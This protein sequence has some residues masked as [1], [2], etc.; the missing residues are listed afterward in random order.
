MNYLPCSCSGISTSL[1]CKTVVRACFIYE[2]T[3]KISIW[4]FG[5]TFENSMKCKHTFF[6]AKSKICHFRQYTWPYIMNAIQSL[7]CEDHNIHTHCW[8]TSMVALTEPNML[9]INLFCR[10]KLE[11]QTI[12]HINVWSGDQEII[13]N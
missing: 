10:K 5:K 8:N 7:C 12:V 2:H 4:I 6:L 3:L 1:K 13:E 9:K 11:G